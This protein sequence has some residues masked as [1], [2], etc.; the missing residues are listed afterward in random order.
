MKRTS[1]MI[2]REGWYYL[3]MMGFIIAG[4]V[5]RDINLLYIMAGMMLGPLLFSFYAASR[6]LR[7]LSLKRRFETLVAADEPLHVE[8]TAS[9][10]V[11]SPRGL[12][13]LVQ[14]TIRRDGDPARSARKADLFFPHVSA[15]NSTDSSYCA[16]LR[17]RGTYRLGPLK[18][19]T[20][21]PLGLVRATAI[22][23]DQETV[24][25]SPKLGVL[26]PAWSRY[27]ALENEGGQKS[28][29]RRGNAEGDFYGMREWR[30]GDSRNWIHWRTSA[31]RMKLTVRQFQQPINQDL[32]VVLDLYRPKHHKIDQDE[33]EKAISLAATL[34]VEQTKQGATQMSVASASAGCFTMH[35][36][37]SPVFRREVMECMAKIEADSRDAL[38]SVLAE[39]LPRATNNARIVLISLLD[40]DLNDTETFEELWKRTDARRAISDVV[41]IRVGTKQFN[42][43]FSLDGPDS[44]LPTRSVGSTKPEAAVSEQKGS[45]R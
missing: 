45:Q 16:R 25:V 20:G 36:M 11:G 19:S 5:I 27:L 18:A 34:V 40:R 32:V 35:G 41:K 29:R 3:G 6:S 42:E 43:L 21:M 4:A 24:M 15:A 39:V 8:I 38:P 10:P 23:E 17:D 31:K 13:L 9:K 44:D 7:K 22:A 28:I 1:L 37:A 26:Q 30:D 14:D 12:A 2:T 33:V